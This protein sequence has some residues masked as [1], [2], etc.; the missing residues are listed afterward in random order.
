MKKFTRLY[1]YMTLGDDI[2]ITQTPLD[3]NGTTV[4]HVEIP[5]EDVGFKNI[6]ISIPGYDVKAGKGVTSEEIKFFK[7]FALN[8]A[9]LLLKYGAVGGIYNA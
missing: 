1:P 4:M 7:Q 8:N 9:H 6:D 2:E 5:D 3:S